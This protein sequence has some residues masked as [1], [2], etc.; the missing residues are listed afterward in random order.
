M[1]TKTRRRI[2]RNRVS[3]ARDSGP[4]PTLAATCPA[5][6]IAMR[7]TE[8]AIAV[9]TA[10]VITAEIRSLWLSQKLAAGSTARDSP[11]SRLHPSSLRPR[12]GWF[13]RENACMTATA[14]TS[15][16]PSTRAVMFDALGTLVELEPPWLHLADALGV[17]PDEH[18]ASAVRAEMDY[19]RDHSHEGRDAD[20]LA[21]LR[22]R[23]AAVLSK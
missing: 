17:Q 2:S 20:S 4:S 5:L 23:C 15:G 19:Y 7:S 6:A 8:N 9:A 14:S 18:L 13:L 3:A 21:E 11:R 12:S 22:G 16:P 1:T 10:I